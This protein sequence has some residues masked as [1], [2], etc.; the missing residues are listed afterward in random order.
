MCTGR[1]HFSFNLQSRLKV[2]G[3][4]SFI[5]S[6]PPIQ[7]WKMSRFFFFSTKGE[8][9][10][11]LIIMN[12]V[13]G[14]RGELAWCPDSFCLGLSFLS[15]FVSCDSLLPVLTDLAAK[16]NNFRTSFSVALKRK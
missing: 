15:V 10:I 7:C 6:P 12:I 16:Y 1:L 4:L 13:R 9:I 8:K 5:R 11:V 2:V 3:T 14:R